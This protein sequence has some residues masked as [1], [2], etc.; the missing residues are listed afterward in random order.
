MY[1]TRL[2]NAVVRNNVAGKRRCSAYYRAG[3]T[4][5]EASAATH[6]VSG[7]PGAIMHKYVRA[8]LSRG[9]G[10]KQKRRRA[11][12]ARR[13]RGHNDVQA[14]HAHNI[15]PKR[16]GVAGVRILRREHAT[17]LCHTQVILLFSFGGAVVSG[18]ARTHRGGRD[19]ITRVSRLLRVHSPANKRELARVENQSP[20]S[21]GCA[22][23]RAAAQQLLARCII[24]IYILMCGARTYH[25][26]VL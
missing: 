2:D 8:R 1:R 19:G 24:Y 23:T 7:H 21:D 20:R 18:A 15:V 3:P 16:E 12:V 17:L 4:G 25:T 13:A 10:E 6:A 26:R 9:H 14:M 5:S 11:Q 22:N